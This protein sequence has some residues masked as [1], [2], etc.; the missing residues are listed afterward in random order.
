MIRGN[1][2]AL[3]AVML[4]LLWTA[5]SAPAQTAPRQSEID[6][7]GGLH[8]AAHLGDAATI[9]ALASAG[10]DLEARDEAGR[11]PLHVAAFASREGAVRA[12]ADRLDEPGGDDEPVCGAEERPF[13]LVDPLRFRRP[14]P[15]V[16]DGA[17]LCP[18]D[19]Q[20]VDEDQQA[21]APRGRQLLDERTETAGATPRHQQ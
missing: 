3:C 14:R 18:L 9:L 20:V 13:D 11:T 12:L 4:Q 19:R 2:A 16:G 21:P 6:A 5:T 15:A 10:A 1:V 7:Y 17:T 8:A